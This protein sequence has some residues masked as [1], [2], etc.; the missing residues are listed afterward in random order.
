MQPHLRKVFENM[1]NLEFHEDLTIHSMF[2]GES[3]QIAF[4]TPLNPKEKGVEFWMSDLEDMMKISV[5][6]ALKNSVDDYLV[7]AR[8]DWGLVH[9]GQCVLN[10]SQVHWTSEVE[11]A[12]LGG[13]QSVNDYHIFLEDTLMETVKLVRGNITAQ[14]A[15]TLGALIV[16]DV[17]AKDVVQRL[18]DNKVVTIDD[19]DW[20]AQLRY[21][22]EEDNCFV[23]CIQTRFPTITWFRSPGEMYAFCR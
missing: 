19:F 18:I 3:E 16:I 15:M 9:P 1:N 10:G 6:H 2:S 17:H 7:K 11:T 21:Y 12:I 22:W 4:V 13:L 8:N 14:Q 23:K 20:I 5:R